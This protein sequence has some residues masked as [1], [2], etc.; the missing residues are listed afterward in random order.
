MKELEILSGVRI[1][2]LALFLEREKTLV[3]SDTHLGYEECLNKKGIMV[4]KFQYKDIIEHLEEILRHCKPERIVINGDL[5]HEFG[6]ISEQ[7][8]NEV[9]RFLDFLKEYEVILV[10]GN[11]DN[12]IGPIAGRKNVSVV[13]DYQ[14]GDF[15]ITHGNKIPDDRKLG[16]GNREPKTIIIG[17]EHPAL[18]LREEGQFEKV[19]CFLTGRWQ[20]KNLV[21][22]PSLNF[23]TEGVDILQERLLSPLL[24]DISEFKAYCI[25]K[26]EILYFG[27]ISGLPKE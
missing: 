25:E 5:K 21:V 7:E 18:G 14:T 3:F 2:G 26:N 4:P 13:T 10:K 12:I 1:V 15:L 6:F 16:T 8:W 9:L 27:K 23:I 24:E 17:H 11:H 22:L 20:G 19:K